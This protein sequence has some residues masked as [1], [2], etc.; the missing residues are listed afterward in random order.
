MIGPGKYDKVCTEVREKMQAK[1]VLLIVID[2][3]KGTGFSAQL[4]ATMLCDGTVSH[5]LREMAA[6]IEKE[7]CTIHNCLCPQP[8]RKDH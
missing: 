1:G 6:Q 7:T 5:I 4:S 3:E 2:G 8:V